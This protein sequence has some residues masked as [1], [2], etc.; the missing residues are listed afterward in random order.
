M[1]RYALISAVLAAGAAGPALAGVDWTAAPTVADMAAL[2]PE[3]AKA[4][5]IGGGVELA[6]TVASGGALRQCDVLAETPR[7]YGFGA[8]ARKLTHQMRAEPVLK[9]SEVRVPVT[10]PAELAKGEPLTAKTPMW[11]ALPTAAELQAV[12][13]KTPGGPNDI[14]VTLLCDVEDGGA[15]TGCGVDREEPGGHGFGAAVLG[16][17]SK[18]RVE[19]MSAEGMPTVGAKVRVPVRFD[20]KPV[21]QAAK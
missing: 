14:R 4:E 1:L 10:F 16:L 11:T 19:L 15:L 7:G 13:P 12:V 5:G 20:L 6:C 17:A 3:K 2:Y 8:A 9:G 18:F 21:D